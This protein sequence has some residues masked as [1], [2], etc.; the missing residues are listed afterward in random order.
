M[1]LSPYLGLALLAGCTQ[2]TQG[3]PSLLPR[4]IEGQS[5]A[6]PVRTAPVA[7]VDPALDARIVEI[8]TALDSSAKAF[9]SGAQE[10]EAKIAVAR[11]LPAGSSPWLDAQTALATLD[12]LRAP[13]LSIQSDLEDLAITRGTEGKPPYPAIDAAAAAA[14]AISESQSA[15]IK[16]LEGALAAP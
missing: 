1:R 10:A 13:T 6:E 2:G 7:T 15:R 9:T 12:T 5:M 11:G 3:Y 4:P 14:V 16:S 8:R